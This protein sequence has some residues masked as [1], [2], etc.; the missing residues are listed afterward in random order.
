MF[1][2]GAYVAVLERLQRMAGHLLD[3]RQ[4]VDGFDRRAGIAW[5]EF[6]CRGERQRREFASEGTWL[7]PQVISRRR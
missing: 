3:I 1:R 6:F 7:D 4:P 5:L 2:A